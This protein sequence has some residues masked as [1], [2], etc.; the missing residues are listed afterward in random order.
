MGSVDEI[1]YNHIHRDEAIESWKF[2]DEAIQIDWQ[3]YVKVIK[4]FK[5][6]SHTK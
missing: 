4:S 6:R 1:F 5:P 3:I 2:E